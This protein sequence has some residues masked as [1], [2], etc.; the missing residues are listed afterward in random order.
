[1]PEFHDSWSYSFDQCN[2]QVTNSKCWGLHTSIRHPY[3]GTMTEVKGVSHP[4][5]TQKWLSTERAYKFVIEENG[6]ESSV[7]VWR[8]PCLVSFKYSLSSNNLSDQRCYTHPLI[9]SLLQTWRRE[10]WRWMGEFGAGR[11]L[12]LVTTLSPAAGESSSTMRLTIWTGFGQI[13]RFSKR[14]MNREKYDGTM[15]VGV[16]EGYGNLFWKDGS[17][18]SGQVKDIIIG[19]QG[20][21]F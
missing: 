11:Q 15:A 3:D 7:Y 10:T 6:E 14:P 17:H 2:W 8:P 18:Y 9:L 13:E 12:M 20:W 16:M 1:M 21:L 5:M 4:L 19:L